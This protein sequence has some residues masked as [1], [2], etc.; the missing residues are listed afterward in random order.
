M[1]LLAQ[2]A[3]WDATSSD[4]ELDTQQALTAMTAIITRE[5]PNQSRTL[6]VPLNR[7]VSLDTTRQRRVEALVTP[8]WVQGLSFGEMANSEPSDFSV[9]DGDR[10]VS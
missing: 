5:R 8:R 6:F 1:S 3:S 4:D 9:C 2:L 10:G 7:G